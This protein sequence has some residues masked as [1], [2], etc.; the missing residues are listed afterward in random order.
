MLCKYKQI[1]HETLVYIITLYNTII[2]DAPLPQADEA[3]MAS[4]GARRAGSANCRGK[5]QG[6]ETFE[7]RLRHEDRQ[8]LSRLSWQIQPVH[9]RWAPP[10]AEKAWSHD[11]PYVRAS[12]LSDNCVGSIITT[13]LSR[14]G[15][16]WEPEHCSDCTHKEDN[17]GHHDIITA[18]TLK[19]W[20]VKYIHIG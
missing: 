6:T 19:K 13:K 1:I 18:E 9:T 2:L 5:W 16:L 12:H 17:V 15:P 20:R 10:L 8:A 11:Q 3:V 14:I 7:L 4:V